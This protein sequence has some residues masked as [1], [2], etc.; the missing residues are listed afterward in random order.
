ML[1]LVVSIQ[2]NNYL[3]PNAADAADGTA[4]SLSLSA[5]KQALSD[6]PDQ[7]PCLFCRIGFNVGA[8]Y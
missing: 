2:T 1:P 6:G 7:S 4:L 5:F 8:P 3:L